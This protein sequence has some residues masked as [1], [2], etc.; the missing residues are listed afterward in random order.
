MSVT[1]TDVRAIIATG[2]T[3][4]QI[5]ALIAQAV[6]LTANCASASAWGATLTDAIN[7][8]VTAHMIASAVDPAKT[9]QSLG[10]ASESFQRAQA[11]K[12]FFGTSYGQTAL[13]LDDSGCLAKR[14]MGATLFKVL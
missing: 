3:D 1:A 12:G 6:L 14:G 13:L 5:N 10:D 7:T 8:W 2:L 4:N 11:G 9:S